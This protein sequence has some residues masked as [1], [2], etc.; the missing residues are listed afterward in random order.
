MSDMLQTTI[1]KFTFRVPTDRLY[2]PEGLWVLRMP[3]GAGGRVRVGMTD[4]LQQSSGDLAFAEGQPV[5]TRVHV[6]DEVG[7]VE[8]IKVNLTL[9][10]PVDGTV[11][12]VNPL[13]K[14]APE[15]INQD[16]YGKG[17]L[18]MVEVTDWEAQK[19][20]LLDPEAY[21]AHMKVQAEA[22]VATL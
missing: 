16:P 15:V 13:L 22:E 4:Y 12:G 20:R 3:D 17:W 8:T 6:G 18:V 9:A 11:V 5:G 7:L 21:F 14:T 10:S 19:A 2:S 1:D